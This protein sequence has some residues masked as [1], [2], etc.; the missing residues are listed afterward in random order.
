MEEDCRSSHGSH[1]NIELSV[2]MMIMAVIV[3]MK[4]SIR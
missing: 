4:T 2:I 3:L 1:R